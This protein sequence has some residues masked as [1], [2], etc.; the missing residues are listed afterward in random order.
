MKSTL[1]ALKM[2]GPLWRLKWDPHN[3]ELLLCACML[4]GAHI[5]HV[6]THTSQIVESYYEHKNICYG[7][8]WSYLGKD[9]ISRLQ[10]SSNRIIGTCSFYDHLMCI[11]ELNLENV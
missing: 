2:P 11:S 3:Y 9:A 10:C 6:E 8:D 5:V 4:G 7:A 1:F